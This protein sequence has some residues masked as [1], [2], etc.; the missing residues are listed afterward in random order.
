M[1]LPKTDVYNALKTLNCFVSQSHPPTFET[2]PAVIFRVGDNS[3]NITLSNNISV[4]NIEIIIDIYAETSSEASEV[5]SQV[6]ELMRNNKY[7][8]IYSTDVPNPG[9]LFHINT[10]FTTKK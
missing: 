5:L 9:E 10:R 4:Q 1:Y 8:L 3:V 7:R 6:E 2:L